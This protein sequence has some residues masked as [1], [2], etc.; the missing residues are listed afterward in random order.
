MTKNGAYGAPTA[1]KCAQK[2]SVKCQKYE[3]KSV[4]KTLQKM[5]EPPAIRSFASRVILYK[6][7]G[8]GSG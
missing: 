4:L 2:E 3:T 8:Q 1:A 5:L 6:A 7:Y